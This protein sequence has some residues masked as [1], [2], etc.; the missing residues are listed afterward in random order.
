MRKRKKLAIFYPI[1]QG[2]IDMNYPHAGEQVEVIEEIYYSF[3]EPDDP[4]CTIRYSDGTT[5]W[6]NKRD[7]K[8]I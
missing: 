4:I 7:L 2:K 1:I 8:Y 5:G 3:C 6:W